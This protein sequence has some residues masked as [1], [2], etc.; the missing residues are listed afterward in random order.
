MYQVCTCVPMSQA[1][2]KCPIHGIRLESTQ[3]IY[4]GSRFSDREADILH[5]GH[6]RG[7]LSKSDP[8]T[9][10]LKSVSEMGELADAVAKGED[11]KDHVGDIVVTLILLCKQSGTT[12]EDC[13]DV[14]WDEIKNR[15]G[16]MQNGT[17]VKDEKKKV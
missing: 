12:I 16:K 9:Q 3:T 7:I 11:I 6:V 13:L 14:A 4:S 1:D 2:A 15:T 17:F 8:K 5:W 10:T